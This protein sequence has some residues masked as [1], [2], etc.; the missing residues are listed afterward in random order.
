MALK[1]TDEETKILIDFFKG[2]QDLNLESKA[3]LIPIYNKYFG[4]ANAGDN[5]SQWRQ[6]LDNLRGL[7]KIK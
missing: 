2:A 1:I 6:Y 7:V 4:T 3:V 5:N